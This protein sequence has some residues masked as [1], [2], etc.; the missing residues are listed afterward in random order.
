MQWS[1]K[2]NAGFSC[3]EPWL[4]L[5]PDWPARN[6]EILRRESRS[7]YGLYRR[8]IQT[9]KRFEAFKR[10]SY[11]SIAA[12]RDMLIYLRAFD[13]ERILIMLNLGAT[14]V[15]S[16]SNAFEGVI[17]VSTSGKHESDFVDQNTQLDANEGLVI[18]LMSISL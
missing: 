17:L 7:I 13:T 6:V 2:A 3:F 18:K 16:T 15:L 8:L 5:T 10:G 1:V 12:K 11:H 9:R 4:P 14:P